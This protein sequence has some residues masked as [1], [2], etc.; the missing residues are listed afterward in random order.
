M[1]KKNPDPRG[2]KAQDAEAVH[3]LCRYSPSRSLI[4]GHRAASSR[5]TVACH[6]ILLLCIALLCSQR[7]KERKGVGGLATAIVATQKSVVDI[8][9]LT[10]MGVN[11]L[12]QFFGL[13]DRFFQRILRLS[14]FVS[15]FGIGPL[16]NILLCPLIKLE[17]DLRLHIKKCIY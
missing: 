14:F 3:L 15:E 13:V 9:F 16:L 7:K 11:G 2:P 1:K 8:G 6:H 17:S 10:F 5:H 12:G 4:D